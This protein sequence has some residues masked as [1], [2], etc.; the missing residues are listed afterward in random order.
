MVWAI[1]WA[2]R[3]LCTGIVTPASCRGGAIGRFFEDG[4]LADD[5]KMGFCCSW[6]WFAFLSLFSKGTRQPAAYSSY[7][8][9]LD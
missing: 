1:H 3:G 8:I 4:I 9:F 6:D 7:S 5:C 2:V